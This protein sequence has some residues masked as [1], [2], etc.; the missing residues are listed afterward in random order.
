MSSIG[1]DPYIAAS[2]ASASA[3]SLPVEFMWPA[4]HEKEIS[5]L[6]LASGLRLGRSSRCC[7]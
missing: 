5:V 1:L 7:C 6:I 2:L 4:T 3:R